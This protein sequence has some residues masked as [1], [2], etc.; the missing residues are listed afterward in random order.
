LFDDFLKIEY[1]NVAIS[2]Q[3]PPIPRPALFAHE[4]RAD[5][6]AE[7]ASAACR[8]FLLFK[9]IRKTAVKTPK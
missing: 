1:G 5:V 2:R 7:R 4:N 9:L 8:D 3:A 6:G